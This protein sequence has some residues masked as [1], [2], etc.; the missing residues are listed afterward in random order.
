MIRQTESIHHSSSQFDR[1]GANGT[2]ASSPEGRHFAPKIGI[3]FQQVRGSTGRLHIHIG[4]YSGPGGVGCRLRVSFHSSS[5]ILVRLVDGGG[6]SGSSEIRCLSIGT[7]RTRLLRLVVVMSFAV[8]HGGRSPSLPA[9]AAT[10]FR[11]PCRDRLTNQRGLIANVGN[12]SGERG[13]RQRA[14]ASVPPTLADEPQSLFS[15][16]TQ[17]RRQ[18]I[19]SAREQYVNTDRFPFA[20]SVPTFPFLSSL[21]EPPATFISSSSN[22]MVSRNKT[23]QA[24]FNWSNR[25]L[26]YSDRTTGNRT[27]SMLTRDRC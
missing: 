5:R 9:A 24:A 13:G 2:S 23:D 15:G 26:L 21:S 4:S 19:Q 11:F 18:P 10:C 25:K 8:K 27:F 3:S 1:C 17:Q 16:R 12:Q 14:S 6:G 7:G 22:S 20:G